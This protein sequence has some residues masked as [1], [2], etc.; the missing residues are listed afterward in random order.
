MPDSGKSPVLG[1]EAMTWPMIAKLDN[2]RRHLLEK[3]WRV[4]HALHLEEIRSDQPTVSSF[5]VKKFPHKIRIVGVQPKIG[6]RIDTSHHT[7]P[8][9]SGSGDREHFGLPALVAATSNSES[10]SS[11][12][13]FPFALNGNI[14]IAGPATTPSSS[15]LTSRIFSLDPFTTIT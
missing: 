11:Q 4:E 9:S 6:K 12:M 14:A 15:N 8:C 1:L 3:L 2:K 5:V 7:I 13:A 10:L